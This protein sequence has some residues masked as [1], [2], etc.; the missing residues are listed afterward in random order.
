MS[1]LI[2]PLLVSSSHC[3]TH[4]VQALGIY[5]LGPGSSLNLT[6]EVSQGVTRAGTVHPDSLL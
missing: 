2:L 5:A 6:L 1:L 4:L 3:N